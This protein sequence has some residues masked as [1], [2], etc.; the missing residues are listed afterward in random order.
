VDAI[1][2]A[3]CRGGNG[4][5]VLVY[6]MAGSYINF[7]I[8]RRALPLIRASL[9]ESSLRYVGVTRRIILVNG[10]FMFRIIWP[11]VRAL[12]PEITAK[13]VHVVTSSTPTLDDFSAEA[14]PIAAFDAASLPYSL[15]GSVPDAQPL[16][17]LSQPTG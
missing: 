3:H 16:R 15:G 11:L 4:Q 2:E 8:A 6:D 12:L 17:V 9:T 5:C 14:D 7:G 10:P 13:K 1:R